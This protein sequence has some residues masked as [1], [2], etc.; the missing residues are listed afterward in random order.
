VD[1][2]C[3]RDRLFGAA[4]AVPDS[5]LVERIVNR[6]EDALAALH[7]R[8]AG[9]LYRRLQ[10]IVTDAAT[11][12]EVL[13]DLFLHVWRGAGRFDANRGSL[14]AW[15]AV[16]ARSRAL[17]RLRVAR[18]RENLETPVDVSFEILRSPDDPE[19]EA[20]R[21]QM[22]GRLRGALRALPPRQKEA[23][24][25]AYLLGMTQS[26]IAARIGAPLGT[27][28]SRVRAAVLSLK[29]RLN[30]TSAPPR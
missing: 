22:T 12:E 29:Q 27:V 6:D 18:R 11:A 14:A 15:L 21:N 10:R 30:T 1:R 9:M 2:C 26:E 4:A 20:V 8:Y 16:T 13:Q 17:S 24:E 23:V 5:V 25:L 7:H 19:I 3:I 28:K